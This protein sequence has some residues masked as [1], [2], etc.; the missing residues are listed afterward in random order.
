MLARRLGN[1]LILVTAAIVVVFLVAWPF[2]RGAAVNPVQWTVPHPLV[3]VCMLA[4][5]AIASLGAGRTRSV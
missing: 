2:V 3:A 5:V 1:A 4:F